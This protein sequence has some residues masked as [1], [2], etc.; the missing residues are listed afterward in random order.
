MNRDSLTAKIIERKESCLV[1]IVE[2]VADWLATYLDIPITSA[3]FLNV[4]ENGSVLC[5]LAARIYADSQESMNNKK[6][7]INNGKTGD[8]TG[9]SKTDAADTNNVKTVDNTNTSKAGANKSTVDVMNN[10]KNK[11]NNHTPATPNK[12]NKH[13]SATTNKVERRK[14]DATPPTPKRQK[15][16]PSKIP[17]FSFKYHLEA[18]QGSFFARENAASFIQWCKRLGLQDSTLF[19]SEGLVFQTEQTNIVNT[20]LEVRGKMS[21]DEYQLR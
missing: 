4:L 11:E 2:D 5:R 10:K 18:K 20:L 9:D 8:G 16:S 6:T 7:C 13:T 3:N 12:E 14:D 17:P 15:L 21:Q 1:P 19:E